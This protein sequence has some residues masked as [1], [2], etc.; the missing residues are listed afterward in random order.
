MSH[1]LY[2][3]KGIP[4]VWI[5]RVGHL[6]IHALSRDGYV[7]APTSQLL[8]DLDAE[9]IDQCLATADQYDAVQAFRQIIAGK[10]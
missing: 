7:A 3:A 2:R 9:T 6:Q 4:E 5:C 10:G 1:P 8:P